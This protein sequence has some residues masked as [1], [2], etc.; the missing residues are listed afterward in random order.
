[1]IDLGLIDDAVARKNNRR[2]E[3]IIAEHEGVA[4]GSYT[5]ISPPE[6]F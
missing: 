5:Q 4:P 3:N 2:D 6:V 1:V